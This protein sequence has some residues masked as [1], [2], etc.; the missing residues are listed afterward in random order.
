MMIKYRLNSNN[1]KVLVD[2]SAPS[3]ISALKSQ[4]NESTDYLPLLDHRKKMKMRDIYTGMTVIPIPF[5]TANK[6]QILLNLKELLDAGLVALNLE[7]HANLIL[8][9]RTA[10]ATDLI[11]DKSHTVSNDVL[12]AFCLSCMRMTVNS[13]ETQRYD[14]PQHPR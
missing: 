3:V 5:N 13:E 2:A 1:T 10:T 14:I 4:M 7:K 12:D 6:K 11:L 8:A 9:L